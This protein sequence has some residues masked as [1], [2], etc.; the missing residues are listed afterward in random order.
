[1]ELEP[2]TQQ[3]ILTAATEVFLKQGRDG[4]RMKEIAKQAGINQALLHYYFRSKQKLYEAVFECVFERFL[5]GF[6]DAIPETQD[7]QVLMRHFVNNY[8]D[9]LA[10]NPDLVPFIL[11]E[12]R[13]GGE[14]MGR[15]LKS[16]LFR[17]GEDKPPFMIQIVQEA[18]AKG[19]IRPVDPVQFTLSLF[20]ACVYP[21]IARPI[22][23]K[24]I[25]G[26][27]LFSPEFLEQRKEEIVQLFW[28]GVRPQVGEEV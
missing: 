14:T 11:W 9:R 19:Q 20:G 13:G 26:L 18:V 24:V 7:V 16:H 27:D 3:R 21:F 15:L 17:E 1:M 12:I 22:L 28:N 23:E 8:L 6:L 5:A 2:D 25:P 10:E 4:A